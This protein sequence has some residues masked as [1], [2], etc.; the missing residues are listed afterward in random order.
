MSVKTTTFVAKKHIF[1]DKLKLRI[2]RI[3]KTFVSL[4]R[5]KVNRLFFNLGFAVIAS[6]KLFFIGLFFVSLHPRNRNQYGD[7]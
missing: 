7:H 2:W 3:R 1:V 5:Q 6:P 4:H